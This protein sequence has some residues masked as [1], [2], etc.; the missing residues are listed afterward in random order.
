M[1]HILLKYINIKEVGMA[2]KDYKN[3]PNFLGAKL[4]KVIEKSRTQQLNFRDGSLLSPS[5]SPT[6][7][8]PY[9]S[10]FLSDI[11][12]LRILNNLY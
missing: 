9:M 3:H 8:Y 10:L 4:S 11:V 5:R 7:Q 1:V 6:H 12:N 2:F